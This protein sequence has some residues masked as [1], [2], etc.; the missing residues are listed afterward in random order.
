MHYLTA[1]TYGLFNQQSLSSVLNSVLMQGRWALSCSS[2]RLSPHLR[3]ALQGAPNGAGV[4]GGC[5]VVHL[6]H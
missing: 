4:T 3:R 5:C 2:L 6:F 1:I